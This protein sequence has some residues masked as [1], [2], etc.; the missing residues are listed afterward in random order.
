MLS[1]HLTIALDTTRASLQRLLYPPPGVRLSSA[2]RGRGAPA[3]DMGDAKRRKTSHRESA[4]PRDTAASPPASTEASATLDGAP[5]EEP[6][7][8]QKTFK[9]LVGRAPSPNPVRLG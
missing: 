6:A 2:Y 8:P 4:R 3:F 1:S 5:A 9:D 7:E